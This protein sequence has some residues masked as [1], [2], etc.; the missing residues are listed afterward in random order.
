MDLEKLL[1]LQKEPCIFVDDIEEHRLLM[2]NKEDYFKNFEE[3]FRF[4]AAHPDRVMI[5]PKQIY[6][7]PGIKG[8]FRVMP[9][10]IHGDEGSI[11]TVKLVGTDEEER[12][13][14]D[15]IS[16]GKAFIFHPTD[17]YIM[18]VFDACILSSAR[19]G[20]SAALGF[21]YL[22]GNAKRVGII[23]CGRVGYYSTEFISLFSSVETFFCY[24]TNPMNLECFKELVGVRGINCEYPKSIDEVKRSSDALILSTYSP[25]SLVSGADLKSNHIQFISSSGA[26]ADNLSELDLSVPEVISRVYVDTEHSLKVADLKR[27]ITKGLIRADD[28]TELK[29]V[30]GGRHHPDMKQIRL[31]VTT[32]FAFLDCLTLDYMYRTLIKKNEHAGLLRP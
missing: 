8:D 21:K 18:G 4:W 3:G 5:T 27:W 1:R 26:D 25:V 32:G 7:S 10:Q 24:D 22:G 31:F 19:T 28:V 11:N 20:A 2:E 29:E 9:C 12:V 14:K 23:G 16:V 17:N 6:T 13:V 30:I 15:K